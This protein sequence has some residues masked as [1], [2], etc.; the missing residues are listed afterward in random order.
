MTRHYEDSWKYFQ[1]HLENKECVDIGIWMGHDNKRAYEDFN[2]TTTWGIEPHKQLR[3]LCKKI[4]P[5]VKLVNSIDQVQDTIESDAIIM[6]GVISL[7]GPQWQNTI[8]EIFA[9]IS[10]PIVLIRHYL[11]GIKLDIGS[12]LRDY[13]LYNLFDYSHAPAIAEI[14]KVMEKYNYFVADYNN[15]NTWLYRKET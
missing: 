9:K 13:N 15:Q 6:F 8:S 12:D 14:H 11:D 7:F 10:A 4:L 5:N 3:A 2:L 1:K